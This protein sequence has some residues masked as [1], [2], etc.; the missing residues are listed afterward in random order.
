MEAVGL[1][2]LRLPRRTRLSKMTAMPHLSDNHPGWNHWYYLI[3]TA[4][5][6][7]LRGDPRGW[8]ERH[9]RQH[10]PGDYKNPPP[11]SKFR[12]SLYAYSES[13]LK[14]APQF[15]H[16]DDRPFIGETIR[17]TFEFQK[18]RAEVIS[19]GGEHIHALV[20]CPDNNPEDVIGRSKQFVWTKF[21]EGLPRPLAQAFWAKRPYGKPIRDEQHFVEA[22]QYILDHEQ[23]GAWIW[24]RSK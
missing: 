24:W 10:V 9:H 20:Q 13:L 19:T 18:T 2:I 8:R 23:E 15:F 3:A 11:D 16:S 7:W 14:H 6:Q 12:R 5:G 17:G 21:H 1:E 4:Y 22:V